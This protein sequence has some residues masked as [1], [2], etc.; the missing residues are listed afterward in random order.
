MMVGCAALLDLNR[1]YVSCLKLSALY[2]EQENTVAVH[3]LAT[4]ASTVYV[5]S[6][7]HE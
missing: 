5:Q 7:C 1:D 3:W 6:R 2:H 4:A